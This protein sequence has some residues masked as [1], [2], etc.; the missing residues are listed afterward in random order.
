MHLDLRKHWLSIEVSITSPIDYKQCT[1]SECF[2]TPIEVGLNSDRARIYTTSK[3]VR[4]DSFDR[5]LSVETP[6]GIYKNQ[7]L[8]VPKRYKPKQPIYLV[9]DVDR[10]PTYNWCE[11]NTMYDKNIILGYKFEAAYLNQFPRI[12]EQVRLFVKSLIIKDVTIDIKNR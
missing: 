11:V 2:D 10:M 6:A 4:D 7:E 5:Y 1:E 3:P 8:L 12:D 9:C